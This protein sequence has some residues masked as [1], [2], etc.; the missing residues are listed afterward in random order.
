[1][2]IKNLPEQAFVILPSTGKMVLVKRGEMGYYPQREEN[3]EWGVENLHHL[4]ERMGVTKAQAKAMGMASRFGW[5]TPMA[6][7]DN[8]D[9][10]GNW[11]K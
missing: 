1:M 8:Y 10:D 5:D 2:T 4:N 3:A 6:D 11:I 9:E 7:P